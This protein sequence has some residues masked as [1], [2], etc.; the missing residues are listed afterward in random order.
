[1]TLEARPDSVTSASSGAAATSAGAGI[2]PSAA[3]D[4]PATSIMAARIR[5]DET[6]RVR[7]ILLLVFMGYQSIDS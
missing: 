6:V 5:I 4:G 3:M 2:S 1:M 7:M